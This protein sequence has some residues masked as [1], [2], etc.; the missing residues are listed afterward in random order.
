MSRCVLRMVMRGSVQGSLLLPMLVLIFL[1]VHW[2]KPETNTGHPTGGVK[3]HMLTSSYFPLA[4]HILT[5]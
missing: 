1:A 3:F 2:C 5:P 4:G